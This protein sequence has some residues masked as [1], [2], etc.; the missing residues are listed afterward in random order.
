MAVAILAIA[1][2]YLGSTILT[3]L[4]P[5]YRQTFGISELT[6]TEVYEIYVLGNLTVLAAFGRL[7]DQIGRRLTTYIALAITAL[8]A[9]CF[10]LSDGVGGLL[11]GRVLN[12]FAA[13]LGA[14][15]LT[16]WCAELEPRQDRARAAAL[17]SAGN[18]A[19]LA[20]GSIAAGL[21]GQYLPSPLR[22]IF[23]AF[24]GVLVVVG[25]LIFRVKE[26]VEKPVRHLQDVSLRPRIGVPKEIRFAFIAPACMALAAF[27]LGGF[28]A[29]LVPGVLTGKLH[30]SNIAVVGAVVGLFFGAACVTAMIA[31]ALSSRSCMLGGTAVLWLGVALLLVSEKEASM[32][33]LLAATLICGAAMAL[34]YRGSL[35]VINEISP[36]DRRAEVVSSYLLVCY[37]G[38]S[39]PV[40]GVGLLSASLGAW[41]AHLSFA[42]VVAAFAL[43][44][45][46]TVLAGR[47]RRAHAF[48]YQSG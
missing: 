31:R 17:V 6:V 11:I 30:D 7:S 29:S 44:A 42:S 19:G 23:I 15:A 47:G 26:T 39:L 16:A 2:L 45:A 28:Y 18:L 4:Y 34:G 41:T 1:A 43:V 33:L 9:V 32:P 36:Q 14:G 3:P 10:L 24:L 35:Q 25:L 27:A 38:N 13:G 22:L 37:A 20:F 12:G 5:L 48:H 40:L 46:V 8:S 21:F